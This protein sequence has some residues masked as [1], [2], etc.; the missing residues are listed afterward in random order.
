MWFE[1]DCLGSASCEH[2]DVAS[3]AG[4][5]RRDC[6][7]TGLVRRGRTSSARTRRSRSNA[8]KRSA[9]CSA[10]F[11]SSPTNSSTSRSASSMRRRYSMASPSGK[12][13]ESESA[14][15]AYTTTMTSA[16]ARSVEVAPGGAPCDHLRHSRHGRPAE[17]RGFGSTKRL[18]K[19]HT[20]FELA[21]VQGLKSLIQRV[22]SARRL[23]ACVHTR[24]WAFSASRFPR[25]YSVS[26]LIRQ[27]PHR[28]ATGFPSRACPR[29]RGRAPPESPQCRCRQSCRHRASPLPGIS[30]GLGP[31]GVGLFSRGSRTARRRFRGDPVR[32][33]VDRVDA[34]VA[35]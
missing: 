27:H 6:V 10:V 11:P 34:A 21:V 7:P 1:A 35:V 2:I 30:G 26:A 13:G 19:A 24:L 22:E 4:A 9:I 25:R 16:E 28:P 29:P 23:E 12:V 33:E 32:L 3:G 31:I 5:A 17:P 18:E 15:L 20:G 14:I 8:G